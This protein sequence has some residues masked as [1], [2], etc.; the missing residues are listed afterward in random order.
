MAAA[1]SGI[2]Q[3]LLG[4]D[5]ISGNDDDGGRDGVISEGDRFTRVPAATL[6]APRWLLVVSSPANAAR[7]GDTESHQRGA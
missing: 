5:G 7:R 3:T 4:V 1:A 6:H 2:V